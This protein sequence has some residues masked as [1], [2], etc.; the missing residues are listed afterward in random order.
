MSSSVVT[1]ALWEVWNNLSRLQD[2]VALNTDRE[3]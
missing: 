3:N 1:M 2:G